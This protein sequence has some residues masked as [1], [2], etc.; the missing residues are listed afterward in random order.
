MKTMKIKYMVLA[1]GAL[2]MTACSSDD[3]ATTDVVVPEVK[4]DTTVIKADTV[5]YNTYT[6]QYRPQ[7]HYTPA[8]N[9]TN[10][11][12]GM[13]YADGVWHLYY[14]YNPWGRDWGNMSWGHATST[15]LMHW[16][17]QPV[18]L[19]ADDLGYI[20]SGS[21]VVDKNNVTGFGENAII[22]FY[23][24]HGNHEQQSMAYS[25]DG[26]MTFTKYSGNPIITNTSHGDFRDPKVVWD[27]DTQMWYMV[28]ALGGEHLV[29]I[30]KSSNLTKW[31]VCSTFSA[32]SYAGCTRGAWECPDLFT[33]DYNGEKKWVLT[34]NV[35][36]GGPVL[37]SGTMYF[38]GSFDGKHFVA[39]GYNYPLWE[40]HGMDD[41]AS[42]TWS[43]TGDR[44]VCIGWMNNQ[45]YSGAYPVNPWRSAMTLP[46]EMKLVEYN[47]QP[48]L[49]ATIVSEISKIAEEWQT[50][51]TNVMP[52][53]DAYQLNVPVNLASGNCS[54]K[55]ANAS[56]QEYGI[57]VDAATRS[58][59]LSRTTQSGLYSFSNNFAIP[60]MRSSL[61]TDADQITLCI[62]VDQSSVEVTTE[63]GSVI[64]STLVFPE[65]IYDRV[66]ISG[67]NTQPQFRNLRRVWD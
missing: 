64:M 66:Y 23:T 7:I 20:Y 10:D 16:K 60:S 44:R 18:A 36:G 52:V 14:Q 45:A 50:L 1:A 39:D 33:M 65:T 46:R 5:T 22:A 54:I 8:K 42:V 59:I 30:Y 67:Q 41:Y 49:K 4:A 19:Y 24:S 25:T 13:V 40:D 53:K 43:N 9:W 27:D 15:D 56:G 6:E 3:N 32:S 51:G 47:G 37:G 12:N 62:Y 17:E 58:L 2:L 31:T 63:D 26:G 28:I 38:V 21:A 34:V 29:Q 48:L 57:T 55:L 35:S 11:P 61:Y